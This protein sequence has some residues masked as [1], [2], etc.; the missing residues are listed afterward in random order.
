[1]TTKRKNIPSNPAGKINAAEPWRRMPDEGTKTYQRFVAYCE[2]G[3]TRS[4]AELWR[5]IGKKPSMSALR[6]QCYKWRWQDRARAYDQ[7]KLEKQLGDRQ[8][9]RESARQMLMDRCADAADTLDQIRRGRM[10][11]GDM[12]VVLDRHGEPAGERPVISP[13]VRLK[14]AREILSLAG[15]SPA[16]RY[17]ITG[18]DGGE[19]AL[20]ARVAVSDLSTDQLRSLLAAFGGETDKDAT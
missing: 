9:V 11:P 5:Q 19:L 4:V 16:K 2:M 18:R 8:L 15:L 3:P 6:Q 20:A 13:A 10:S 7:K 12:E 1:M 14:A 17:E